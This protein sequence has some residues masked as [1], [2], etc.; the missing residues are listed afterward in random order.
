MSDALR[1]LLRPELEAL[2]AYATPAAPA[3]IRLD[4][5]ESPWPLPAEARAR[6]AEALS[7]IPLH[8]YPDPRAT[9]L[10]EA[11]ARYA[12]ARPEELVLGVGSD[13]AIGIL[14]TA[15]AR[16]RQGRA[17]AVV[18]HPDPSFSMYGIIGR[19]HG[20]DVVKVPLDAR[21]D[22]DAAVWERAVA[23]HR[24]AMIFLPS[25][26]N[27]TGNRFDPAALRAIIAAAP[28]ALAVLDD[29]Y[30]EFSS[31]SVSSELFEAHENV[32]VLGTVS[33]IGLAAL[34]VGWVRVRPWLAHELEKVRLTYNLPTPSQEIVTLALGP[35]LPVLREQLAAIRSERANLIAMLEATP[36]LAPCRTDAN[37]VLTEVTHPLGAAALAARVHAA[38]IQLRAFPGHPRL[39]EHLRITVGTPDE[40]AALGVALS[41][42]LA[43]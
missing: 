19:G 33:K 29:A 8:R 28:D 39:A 9:A 16:P 5:N 38:G 25:P 14:E 21:F 13:E 11:I 10:R 15:L 24:P 23:E 7:A 32:A 30:T 22:L 12:G 18:M 42:A 34:R 26:N 31:G 1:A 4:G 27:P 43:G 20:H 35:L 17:R 40:N 3:P 36:G 37:F 6:V 2:H 41:R